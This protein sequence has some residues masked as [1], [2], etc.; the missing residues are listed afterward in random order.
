MVEYCF[1]KIEGTKI[2]SIKSLLNFMC[3]ENN[4]NKERQEY[5]VLFSKE[6]VFKKNNGVLFTSGSK[7][8]M[9]FY[10]KIYLNQNSN[11][12]ETIHLDGQDLVLE[13]YDNSI[14][15]IYGGVNNSTTVQHD[16]DVLH[17]YVAPRHLLD[18]Q[19]LSKWENL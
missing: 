2:E 8:Y 6:T 1:T 13:P 5:R 19:D 12:V 9:S 16:E 11:I 7:K 17:F 14:L 4:I 15:I 10:G 3:K 18:L